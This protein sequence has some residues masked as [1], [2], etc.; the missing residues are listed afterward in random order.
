[1]TLHDLLRYPEARAAEEVRDVTR[2]R[3]QREA[4][5]QALL[6]EYL[7]RHEETR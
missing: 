1:M 2:R 6:T 3:I 7:S 5:D 4:E